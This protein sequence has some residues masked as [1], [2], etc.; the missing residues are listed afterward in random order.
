MLHGN[1]SA[2]EKIIEREV[3]KLAQSK[4]KTRG[5]KPCPPSRPQPSRRSNR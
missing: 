2:K 4:A 3:A 5:A 1:Q